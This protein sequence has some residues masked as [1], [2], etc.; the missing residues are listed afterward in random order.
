M[1]KKIQTSLVLQ[2]KNEYNSGLKEVQANL[3]NLNSEMKLTQ[4]QFKE[5]QNSAQAL[6]KKS[7]ILSK[8]YEQASK[9]VEL[10][11]KRLTELREEESR[12]ASKAEE[13]KNKLALAST[14][15]EQLKTSGTATNSM[16]SEQQKV[17]DDLKLKLNNANAEL[18]Q[19]VIKEQQTE[20]AMN[21]A[22]AE[23]LRYGAELEKTNRYLAEAESSTDGLARSIDEYGNETDKA[24]EETRN[25]NNTLETIAKNEAL[26]KIS[27][28]AHELLENFKECIETAESFGYSIAKVQSIAQVSG[29]ELSGMSDEIRRVATE[30][31]FSANEVAEAT[32]QAIS[33]SVDAAEA[34]EFVEDTTKLARAGFTEVTTAVDVLTTAVNAYGKEAN[35][36]AHIADDLVTTQN[37]GKTTVDELAQ[38][39]GNIIPTAAAYNV[40]L[41]QLSSAYVILTRQGINTAN[42]TTYLNGMLNELADS[43][44]D[45]G[46]VLA[47]ETGHTFGELTKQGYTLGDVMDILGNYVDGD[48]ESFANLFSNIRA[49]KGALAIF[50]QG[51]DE[52]NRILEIMGDN[53]GATD[54]AFE[55]MADTAEMTNARLEASVENLKIALGE[56]LT[57][58]VD[59]FKEL[60]IGIIEVI[61]GF[62]EEHPKLVSAMAGATLGI[63]GMATAVTGLATAVAICK[64]AFGDLSGLLAM[65][66]TVGAAGVAGGLAGVA[67]AAD[68]TTDSIKELTA[69]YE[70][71]IEST[72]AVNQST[73]E[74]LK[75]TQNE[76][77]FIDQLAGK[78][79][80]LNDEENLTNVQKRELATAVNELNSLYPELNLQIDENTGRLAENTEGW[81]K[82][83]ETMKKR[84]QLSFIEDELSQ[85]Y[86]QQAEN[87]KA[88]YDANEDLN[89]ITNEKIKIA[90]ELRILQEKNAELDMAELDRMQQLYDRNDELNAQAKAIRDS[91]A[92]LQTANEELAR[93]E[94]SLNGFREQEIEAVGYQI[95]KNGELVESENAVAES[96]VAREEAEAALK[97]ATVQA[98]EAIS[99]Q[100]GLFEEWNAESELTFSEM[101]KRWEGQNEGIN[102]YTEDLKYVKSVID[103]DTDPAIKNLALQMV[104]MGAD[105]AA[106]LHTF[107]EGLKDIGNNTDGLQ[108]LSDMWSTHLDELATAEDIY[109]EI[110]L[111]EEGYTTDSTERFSTFYD[112]SEKAQVDF[113]NQKLENA[114]KFRDDLTDMTTETVDSV[115]KATLDGQQ[116]VTDAMDTVAQ[117]AVDTVSSTWGIDGGASSVFGDMADAVTSSLADRIRNGSGE[118]AA[119][120]HQLCEDAVASFDISGLVERVDQEIAN[121]ATRKA[122]AYGG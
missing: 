90:K 4:T 14:S 74:F 95:D 111:Q 38:S 79:K 68:E 118:V 42:A 57:P 120:V 58:A 122:A 19:T 102:Q 46:Q 77:G 36:T 80:T 39:L 48:S 51:A 109:R 115:A 7:E 71:Q 87:S 52:F 82:N 110:I 26:E 16:I 32:Y 63:V 29:E 28:A 44:S 65:G 106:E 23:Q 53:A 49:G 1:A 60:G 9:K 89:A 55:I 97:V 56:S 75:G 6:S 20:A 59:R 104:N 34:V 64:A 113:Q 22:T 94:D 13:Y 69:E 43:G 121:M 76:S 24:A 116:T 54:K 66:I 27:E 3:K 33:A 112:E 8:E 119:A 67:L 107:C 2:G 92:D 70:K 5:S 84:E 103:S 62:V 96:K 45:V 101:K 85:I 93:S 11:S 83:L 86:R 18:S 108:E 25:L 117:A 100:I 91:R 12:A 98:S 35:T 47:D 31:G 81:E 30:M 41:D 50:N 21:N 15:L 78:I 17:V 72:K 10:Y 61:T 37:L 73:D 105:G 99:K 114:T 40:S 88:L